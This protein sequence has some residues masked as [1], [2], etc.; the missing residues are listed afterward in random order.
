MNN[1]EPHLDNADLRVEQS[2]RTFK[3]LADYNPEV[4][5]LTENLQKEFNNRF[6]KEGTADYLALR[7]EDF[8]KIIAQE[9]LEGDRLRQE[10]ERKIK[11]EYLKAKRAIKARKVQKAHLLVKNQEQAKAEALGIPQQVT[12]E[13][14]YDYQDFSTY[15]TWTRQMKEILDGDLERAKEVLD[16]L[17]RSSDTRVRGLVAEHPR[18]PPKTLERLSKIGEGFAGRCA[19]HPSTPIAVIKRL[20]KKYPLEVLGNP[21][22]P[23]DLLERAIKSRP[24]KELMGVLAGNSSAPIKFLISIVSQ[25]SN[26]EFVE[27][28]DVGID[29]ARN[30]SLPVGEL[31]RLVKLSE[32]HFTAGAVPLVVAERKDLTPELFDV[33]FNWSSRSN[34]GREA[35][36]SLRHGLS[37]NPHTPCEY[38]EDLA[39]EFPEEVASNN[40]TPADVLR[41]LVDKKYPPAFYGKDRVLWAVARNDSTPASLLIYMAKRYPRSRLAIMQSDRLEKDSSLSYLR[42]LLGKTE[43]EVLKLKLS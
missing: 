5:K 37:Q 2:Q 34:R 1:A 32:K 13:E 39:K 4:L 21:S 35:R 18:T 43:S 9:K 20:Y 24:L 22:V 6:A 31:P 26:S 14:I 36:T 16:Y 3:T 29:L 33:F 10:A 40:S 38:F 28:L 12:F 11:E 23:K 30:P 41:K 25:L 7:A 8:L 27:F 17:S 15:T 19:C 42:A